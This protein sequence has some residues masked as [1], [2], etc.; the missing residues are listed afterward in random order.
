MT[1]V[2]GHSDRAGDGRDGRSTCSCTATWARSVAAWWAWARRSCCTAST[3]AAQVHVWLPQARARR[4]GRPHRRPAAAPSST[5]PHTII[6][7]AAVG[8]LL[9]NRRIDAVLL[10][11]DVVCANGDVGT[12]VG[13]LGI[14]R[15][16]AAAS[17]P[18]YVLA[19]RSA[20]DPAAADG[21]ALRVD[22]RSASEQ[23]AAGG[24]DDMPSGR[25]VVF[26]ARLTP[27][28]DVVPADLV[29]RAVSEAD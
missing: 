13:S 25:P 19:P 11:G 3:R 29:E 15:L 24:T 14:A 7:D 23:L 10:R 18:V 16:A 26:G 20:I 28:S 5:C 1:L 8:W 22:L 27:H 6:P 12:V 2:R 4:R 17:V 9:A 21:S